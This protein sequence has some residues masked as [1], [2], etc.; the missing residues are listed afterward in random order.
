MRMFEVLRLCGVVSMLVD[1][2]C[3]H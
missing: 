1:T 2:L 3:G